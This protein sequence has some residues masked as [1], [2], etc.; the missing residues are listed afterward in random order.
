MYS[1]ISNCVAGA[2]VV[3]ALIG[4]DVNRSHE[5]GFPGPATVASFEASTV[6]YEHEVVFTVY[7]PTDFGKAAPLI[8]FNTGWN[9]PRTTNESY[10]VQLA[11]WGYVVIIRQYP[12]YLFTTFV[13]R[14]VEHNKVVVDWALEQNGDP[15]SPLYGRIDP[16]LIGITGYSFGGGVAILATIADPRVDAC[17]ALDPGLVEEPDYDPVNYAK[18]LRVPTLYIQSSIAGFV[19]EIQPFYESTPPPC[20]RVTVEGVAHMQFEDRIV[21]ANVL[22]RFIF[23][24]GDVDSLVARGLAVKYM[25]SWFKVHLEG[26]PSFMP[27]LYGPGSEKDELEGLVT[28]DRDLGI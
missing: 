11:Q 7:Y 13:E 22:G 25:V 10:C 15:A 4:C 26:D 9:Q 18:Q 24:E 23:P 16:E 17:V 1:R 3:C 28:I 2:T 6:F 21:G 14:H 20:M 27:N 8:V 12:S 19:G 5:L